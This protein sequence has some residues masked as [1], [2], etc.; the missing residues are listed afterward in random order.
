MD[1]GIQTLDLFELKFWRTRAE[2]SEWVSET[3]LMAE[4]ASNSLLERW[5]FSPFYWPTLGGHCSS[6][7]TLGKQ[8]TLNFLVLIFKMTMIMTTFSSYW[9]DKMRPHIPSTL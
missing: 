3:H 5:P 4:E 1:L 6:S 7:M 2:S 9:T 8:H